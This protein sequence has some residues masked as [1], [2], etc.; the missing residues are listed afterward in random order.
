MIPKAQ[1]KL[2]SYTVDLHIHSALSPCAENRMTPD[3]VL[4]KVS[5][6]IYTHRQN[7]QL[8][9]Q[10]LDQYILQEEVY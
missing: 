2:I 7:L 6:L 1:E 10:K 8:F 3:E 4:K 9:F 5:L